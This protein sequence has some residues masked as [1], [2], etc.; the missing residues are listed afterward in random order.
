[1]IGYCKKKLTPAEQKY[2]ASEGECFAVLTGVRQWRAYLI[3]G[4]FTIVT[5]HRAL[6]TWL[7][8]NTKFTGRLAR[9][10]LQL[11]QFD[12]EIVYRN[13]KENSAADALSRPT[14][15]C[16]AVYTEEEDDDGAAPPP[17]EAAE[18]PTL[19]TEAVLGMLQ[20]SA[21]PTYIMLRMGGGLVVPQVRAAAQTCVAGGRSRLCC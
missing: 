20:A 12:F 18:E 3:G 2:S 13:G 10:T 14:G 5:D 1:V 15:C 19:P 7:M 17:L 8:T 9:W 4:P 21:A 6:I 11:Q 16:D